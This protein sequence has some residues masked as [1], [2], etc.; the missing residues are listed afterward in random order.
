[1]WIWLRARA[2]FRNARHLLPL[3]R[4][5]LNADEIG[6][7]H[8]D[9]VILGSDVIW[10]YATP[11]A[12]G[13]DPVYFGQ[14][15]NTPRLVSFAASAGASPLDAVPPDYAIKGWQSLYRCS[16]RD[17]HTQLIVKKYS[18]MEAARICDPTF[19]L[20]DEAVSPEATQPP[21]LLVYAA[22][23][24]DTRTVETIRA[25]AREH[26]LKTISVIYPHRWTDSFISGIDPM[27]WQ[28]LIAGAAFVVTS[29]FHGTIFSVLHGKSFVLLMN[30][31]IRDKSFDLINT[32]GLDDRI[33]IG[34]DVTR[35]LKTA[36]S[37]D[38]WGAAASEER[39]ISRSFLLEAL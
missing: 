34:P 9:A 2:A 5:Y 7:T 35:V 24:V 19:H 32:I 4:T 25:F 33:A 10:N 6:E 21:Y 18:G 29:A 28:S 16:V 36:P 30:D 1:M 23:M 26:C 11:P 39:S 27:R 3:T 31:M 17:T 15:L 12:R 38:Q 22:M 14:Y 13:R 8:Y 20:A 37:V